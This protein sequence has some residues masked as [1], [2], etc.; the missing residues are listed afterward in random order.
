M[1]V[2]Y[3]SSVLQFVAQLE[4]LPNSFFAEERKAVQALFPGP[5]A[6]MLP[7]CMKDADAIHLSMTLSD[8]PAIAKAAKI[9][10]CTSRIGPMMVW[11]SSIIISA[12]KTVGIM[13][14]ERI[15]WTIIKVRF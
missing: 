14:E 6:W 1:A 2:L 13:D 12:I 5:T 15:A 9:G 7:G 3:I 11:I 4:E 8:I 10:S